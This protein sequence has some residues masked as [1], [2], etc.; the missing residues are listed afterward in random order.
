MLGITETRLE[1]HLMQIESNAMKNCILGVIETIGIQR[2]MT[3]W[4]I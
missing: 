3:S 1:R 4:F 2:K